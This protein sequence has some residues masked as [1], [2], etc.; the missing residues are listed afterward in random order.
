MSSSSLEL[1]WHRDTLHIS[2]DLSGPDAAAL[3]TRLRDLP[4]P[5]G[6]SLSLDLGDLE[7]EDGVSVAESVNALR[8]LLRRGRHLTLIEAPQMLAHTLYK[9][10]MLDTQPITLVSPREDEGTT[11]N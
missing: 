10:S 7:L 4:L 6:P 11:A 2:G 8:H 3:A 5:D 1:R 9:V